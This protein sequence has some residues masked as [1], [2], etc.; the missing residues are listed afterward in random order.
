VLFNIKFWEPFIRNQLIQQITIFVE[1]IENRIIPSFDDIKNEAEKVAE[2]EWDKLCSSCF[3]PDIDPSDLAEKA[4]DAGVGHYLMLS[5]VKQALLNVSVTTLYHLFEQQLLF[6]LRREVIH[7]SEENNINLMKIAILKEQFLQY[8]IDIEKFSSWS[9]INEL[10]LFANTIKHAEGDSAVKLRKV[11]P[12]LFNFKKDKTSIY[13]SY[14]RV[15]MPLAG[16]DI[17]ILI[18]DLKNYKD[19]ITKFWDE[20]ILA[21]YENN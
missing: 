1:N 13:S 14:S 10:R 17:Y 5:S 20:L 18:E 4:H 8:N 11:R 12:D 16:E 3:S 15:Y 19:A 7:P 9:T 21:M 2:Q 6:F